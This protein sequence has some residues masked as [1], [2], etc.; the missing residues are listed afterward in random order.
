[1]HKGQECGESIFPPFLLFGLHIHEILV[2]ERD[3]F[4]NYPVIH[5]GLK[6]LNDGLGTFFVSKQ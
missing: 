3:S 2:Y 4:V 1:M 5:A 6:Q